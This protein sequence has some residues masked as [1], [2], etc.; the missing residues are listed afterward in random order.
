MHFP[1][2]SSPFFGDGQRTDLVVEPGVLDGKRRQRREAGQR[3]FVGAAERGRR[4]LFCQVEIA[5]YPVR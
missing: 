3:L 4:L 5:E 1:S 2:D